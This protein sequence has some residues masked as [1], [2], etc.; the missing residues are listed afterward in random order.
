VRAQLLALK[1]SVAAVRLRRGNPSHSISSK[2][3]RSVRSSKSSTGLRNEFRHLERVDAPAMFGLNDAVP[4]PSSSR[5]TTRH[6]GES[7]QLVWVSTA[8]AD[9]WTVHRSSARSPAR[10]STDLG[11]LQPA[12]GGRASPPRGWHRHRR[13]RIARFAARS[14]VPREIK[15]PKRARKVK[16]GKS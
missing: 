5:W 7:A 4:G 10:V 2:R 12:G 13:G 15:Q 6:A 1:P 3:V 16:Q 11:Y 14:G 9:R 8:G